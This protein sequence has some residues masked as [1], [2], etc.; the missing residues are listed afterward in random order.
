MRTKCQATNIK[1]IFVP[2]AYAIGECLCDQDEEEPR[3][4]MVVFV[5]KREGYSDEYD[6]LTL[7]LSHNKC[8]DVLDSEKE[9]Q[10][11]VDVGVGTK[12]ATKRM[13][14]CED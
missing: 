3:P 12:P 5:E 7:S 8:G 4:T 13:K 14:F 6:V 9:D 1:Y 2:T 10:S 11:G